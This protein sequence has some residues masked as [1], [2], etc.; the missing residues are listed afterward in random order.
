MIEP[1]EYS[2]ESTG[3]KWF[4]WKELWRYRELFYF[5]TWRDIKIKYKQTVLGFL[6][7]ILQPLFMMLI[8]TFFFGRALNIPSQNLPYPVYVFSGLL[9]WNMFSAGLTS[10]SNS[11]VNNALI[12][13]KIYFPRL[14]IPVSAI[15]VA[16]FDFLMAFIL[17]IGI[18]LYYQQ[19]VSWLFILI[20]PLSLLVAMVA[21]LGLGAWLAA[22]NVK[23][24][25][26][27]YVIPFLVQVMFFLTPVIYPISMLNYPVLKY[28]LAC[29]PMF[30][31][32][33]LFRFPLTGLLPDPIFMAL[34]LTSGLLFLIVG[35]LY[36]KRTEDFFA[37]FA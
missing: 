35:I 22:L 28:L 18:L 20:W 15:L 11:M 25:D 1:I 36:F 24:R 17:F 30:A 7:A 29:S 10:A 19:P 31:A 4:E 21:T 9:I 26:F 16:L 12:I 5:F 8:F 6:W 23:Y 3:R 32:V 37:D 27:R 14:I 34:S 2:I 33:E 13:K